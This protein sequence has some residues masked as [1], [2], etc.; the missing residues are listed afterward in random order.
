[1]A[2]NFYYLLF[3]LFVTIVF[4]FAPEQLLKPTPAKI[5]NRS[6]V[7]Q[8]LLVTILF[9]AV[10]LIVQ[11]LVFSSLAVSIFLIILSGVS[12]AKFHALREPLVFSD[13]AMFSQAFKHP[14]LYFPFLGFWPVVIMPLVIVALIYAMLKI[15]PAMAFTWQRITTTLVVILLCII[16]A[17]RLAKT[18]KLSEDP[19]TDNQD[20]G[21]LNSVF[22]YAIQARSEAHQQYI[23]TALA[24][25]PFANQSIRKSL[26][27][28]PPHLL[29]ISTEQSAQNITVIQSESFF[30]ARRLDVSINENILKNYDA[31]LSESVQFG[32]LD[33]PAWGANTMRTEFSFLTGLKY[34]DMGLYRY[35]PYQYLHKMP[36]VSLAKLLQS[37]GYHCVCIHPHPAS[38]FGRDRIFPQMGFDEFI[39]IEDFDTK[40]TFGPYISDQAVTDKILD[41]SN[42]HSDKPLFI[43]AITMENHGPLHLEKTTKDEQQSYFSE[44]P[45]EHINDL[46][47]YLR[48]LKN[49]DKMV[50]Q[51]TSAYRDLEQSS[52][53]CFYGDH[54]PSMPKIY[55]ELAYKD[56]DSDYFIWNNKI[57][58]SSSNSNQQNIKVDNLAETLL[59]QTGNIE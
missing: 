41:I 25:S 23:K 28:T 27:S 6:I 29:A 55:Q 1:M 18:L 4:S 9:L 52:T 39:D 51:L 30:D 7:L 58:S 14:R 36:V 31:C 50:A 45:I 49:A 56:R 22:A 43:F 11:R 54:I 38:F 59:K 10:T 17:K 26:K 47:V 34:E 35:Y 20:H 3:T 48:H 13:I 33:V 40:Q 24:D 15:E 19:V 57:T 44:T 32:K 12:N 16:A 42:K 46:A 53:I 5:S 21:L 2:V 8:G 37:Q